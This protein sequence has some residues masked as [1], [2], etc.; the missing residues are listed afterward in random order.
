MKKQV[1]LI[2]ITMLVTAL[3]N[4][5]ISTNSDQQNEQLA[6]G[7]QNEQLAMDFPYTIMMPSLNEGW[8]YSNHTPEEDSSLLFTDN[9]GETWSH[10]AIDSEFL[11]HANVTSD[12]TGI[13]IYNRK[14]GEHGKLMRSTDYGQTWSEITLPALQENN[15]SMHWLDEQTGWLMNTYK[16]G[17]GYSYAD[18]Y[19]TADGGEAWELLASSDNDG[20]PIAGLKGSITFNNADDGW[21]SNAWQITDEELWLYATLDG[22]VS[23]YKQYLPFPA[24]NLP[25]LTYQIGN[26]FLFE[27]MAKVAVKV[28]LLDQPTANVYV[29]E[30]ELTA[31]HDLDWQL[32]STYNVN[33]D[34]QWISD[35][36]FANNEF[37]WFH[38]CGELFQ[39]YDGGVTWQRTW[40]HEIS[41][42]EDLSSIAGYPV[43]ISDVVFVDASHGLLVTRSQE[44]TYIYHTKNGGESWINFVPEITYRKTD[45]T[46]S[47][48]MQIPTLSL[49]GEKTAFLYKGTVENGFINKI[50]VIDLGT[51]KTEDIVLEDSHATTYV[52]IVWL[53]HERIGIV[54]HVNPSLDE[55]YVINISNYHHEVYHGIG[56]TIDQ[57]TGKVVYT[58][59]QPHFGEGEQGKNKIID[60]DGNIYYESPANVMIIGE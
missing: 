35:I 55:L 17:L 18:I 13:Y 11:L 54:G 37:G 15:I 58:L 56:F 41:D 10:V 33:N 53:D 20:I 27:N 25:Q 30:A 2:V 49:D 19:Y 23:W 7:Q 46:D 29:Y 1:V 42:D 39:T 24:G 9:L 36:K 34:H 4:G 22:G 12:D 51:A 26:V 45:K 50:G 28:E 48:E 16:H 32:L 3:L 40:H 14:V 60:S 6:T 47:E 43:L 21:I 38:N 52:E 8:A 31:G 5:C 59:P 57:L 44:S